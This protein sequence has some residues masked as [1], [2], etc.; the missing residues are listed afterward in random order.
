MHGTEPQRRGGYKKVG[1]GAGSCN[2]Q[3]ETS[4]REE[5]GCSEVHFCPENGI[6]SPKFSIFV[7]KFTNKKLG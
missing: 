4:N 1:V 2:F 7:R 6:F 3:T 5:N